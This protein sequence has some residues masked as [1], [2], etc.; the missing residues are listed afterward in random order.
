MQKTGP[1]S[2]ARFKQVRI[3]FFFLSYL[4]IINYLIP[5]CVRRPNLA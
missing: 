2:S 1:L 3:L 4:L 5:W